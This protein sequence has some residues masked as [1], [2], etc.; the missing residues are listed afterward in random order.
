MLATPIVVKNNISKVFSTATQRLII[1]NAS[2]A[3]TFDFASENEQ[4][5]REKLF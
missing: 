2:S 3:F 1:G 4:K 5:A